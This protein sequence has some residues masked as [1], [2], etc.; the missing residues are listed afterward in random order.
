M[1]AVGMAAVGL[2]L[3]LIWAAVKDEDIRDVF[4]RTFRPAAPGMPGGPG[5]RATPSGGTRTA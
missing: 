4:A 2:G 3:V 5:M 1:T